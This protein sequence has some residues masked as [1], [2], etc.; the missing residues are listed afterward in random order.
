MRPP[1]PLPHQLRP[2][3]VLASEVLLEQIAQGCSPGALL[4]AP[5]VP[6]TVGRASVVFSPQATLALQCA[7]PTAQGQLTMEATGVASMKVMTKMRKSRLGS[8]I[9][10]SIRCHYRDEHGHCSALSFY[11]KHKKSALWCRKHRQRGDIDVRNRRCAREGCSRFAIYGSDTPL[12]PK[13]SMLLHRM[14]GAP[15][16]QGACPNPRAGR[17]A[18][19]RG[20]VFCAHHRGKA[21][22][23]VRS[24]RCQHPD[25]CLFPA[26]YGLREQVCM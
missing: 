21:D 7:L 24:K 26:K 23:D 18:A 5:S 12:S 13:L 9:V 8:G 1:S 22:H 4:G 14:H 25:G 16:P 3:A 15:P 17:S 10:S 19:V 6:P 11:G 2:D 20:A